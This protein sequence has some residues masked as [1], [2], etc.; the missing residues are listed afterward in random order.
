[1]LIGLLL[2]LCFNKTA[3]IAK[4][5]NRY[6]VLPELKYSSG[7][8]AKI[9][10]SYGADFLWSVAFTEIVQAILC[11]KKDRIWLLLACSILGIAYE[12]MQLVGIANGTA[13]IMDII[14]YL[15]GSAFGI[16]II[17]GGRI[18]EKE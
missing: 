12:I 2:Y 15:C 8:Y 14:V 18:Y 11:L 17:L 13:D 7:L 10:R 9:I 6:I 16:L 5:V 3:F 1:M 4:E